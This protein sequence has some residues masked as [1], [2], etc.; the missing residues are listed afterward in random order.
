MANIFNTTL[1]RKTYDRPKTKTY[2]TNVP[3]QGSSL[4]TYISEQG[5]YDWYWDEV[6][7]GLVKDAELVDSF[8][9]GEYTDKEY[10]QLYKKD[11][12]WIVL[13]CYVG[14]C[15][16]CCSEF[17]DN[18]DTLNAH[19]EEILNK[20]NISS[21]DDAKDYYYDKK[22]TY[23]A[24]LQTEKEKQEK[25]RKRNFAYT[26]EIDRIH[27]LPLE[28]QEQ[29]IRKLFDNEECVDKTRYS[30]IEEFI[31]SAKKSLSQVGKPSLLMSLICIGAQDRMLIG[32]LS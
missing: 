15:T 11:N 30:N 31:D 26:D 16:G 13:E 8:A 3:E 9:H 5:P 12:L 19:I 23:E 28:Q 1:E 18:E 32:E 24:K 25:L 10:I 14:S 20:A 27:K 7:L 6:Q 2:E 29:Q 22:N 21:N 4:F 17:T